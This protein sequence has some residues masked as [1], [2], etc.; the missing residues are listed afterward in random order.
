[1]HLLM[2]AGVL[3]LC[4]FVRQERLAKGPWAIRWQRTLTSFLLP[5]CLLMTTAFAIL[6]MGPGG[7]TFSFWDGN[8]TYG[9]ALGFVLWAA[10]EGIKLAWAGVRFLHKVQ[11]YPRVDVQGVSCLRL[12]TVA[13]F[14]AQ[15]GFWN[16]QMLVSQGLL[17]TLDQEHLAA[18]L[19]H[20]QAHHYYRDTFWFFWLGWLRRITSW[21]PNTQA[22]WD[23]LLALRELR[24][25]SWAAQQVDIFALAE[26]LVLVGQASPTHVES[27][28]LCAGIALSPNRLEERVEALLAGPDATS[29]T[30]GFLWLALVLLPFAALPFHTHCV[31]PFLKA[32]LF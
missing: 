19:S 14:I 4:W 26:S 21:L 28:L 32:G 16:P 10:L 24:A 11:T 13:P 8:I 25:D 7:A 29:Y 9:L 18:V 22:L 12:D 3:A 30:P 1:M 31:C 15:V 20:E 5:P 2:I 27:E 23:E 17:D 6:C